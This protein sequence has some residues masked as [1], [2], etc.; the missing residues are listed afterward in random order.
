MKNKCKFLKDLFVLLVFVF[1]ISIYDAEI[2]NI[3]NSCEIKQDK[4]KNND[5]SI[6]ENE[7]NIILKKAKLKDTVSQH[8]IGNYYWHK[9]DYNKALLWWEK[10]AQKDYIYSKQ[11]ILK[12]YLVNNIKKAKFYTEKYKNTDNEIIMF[13][14]GNYYK[15]TGQFNMAI[16]WYQKSASRG[17]CQ[18][19]NAIGAIYY[20]KGDLYVNNQKAHINFIKSIKM[21]CNYWPKLNLMK[22]HINRKFPNKDYLIIIKFIILNYTKIK[23]A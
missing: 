11:Y 3:N 21:G 5:W 16:N 19:Y 2:E 9:K 23:E 12:Y 20:N 15:N 13:L 17:M 8:L 10:S 18:A 7:F 14:I 22:M 1:A 4:F 6:N